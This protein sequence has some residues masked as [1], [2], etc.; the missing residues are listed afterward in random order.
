VILAAIAVAALIAAP[1]RPGGAAVIAAAA[2]IDA[3]LGAPVGPAFAVVAPLTCFIG[4]ALALGALAQDSGL[5]ARL[6]SALA[7]RT[8]GDPR[9]LYAAVCAVCA[10]ATATVSLDGAVV[11]MVPLLR[12]LANGHRAPFAPL[13]VGCVVVANATSIAVPQGNPT[14]LVVIERLGISPAAFLAHMLLPGLAAAVI[15]AVGVA[16]YE[17]HALCGTIWPSP[18]ARGPFSARERDA[19]LALCAATLATWTALLAGI[20]PWWPFTAVVAAALVASPARRPVSIPWRLAAQVGG[21]LV[22]SRALDLPAL[23]NPGDGLGGLVAIATGLGLCCALASNLPVGAWV[24][25]LLSAGPSAYAATIGLAV[26][27][28]ATPHGS[29]ATL[30]AADLAGP[31]APPLGVRRLAPLALAGVVVATLLVWATG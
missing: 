21:L 7:E 26:G 9:L 20:A 28:L 23:T 12:E 1:R 29:V 27:A 16:I 11:L 31:A 10:T 22:V 4:A 24:A 2:A 6:A 18:R 30:I 17:R 13:F 14:N 8:R 3:V 19:V 5:V 25:G 15:C